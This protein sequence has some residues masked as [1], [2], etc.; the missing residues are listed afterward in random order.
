MPKEEEDLAVPIFNSIGDYYASGKK[1]EK[2]FGITHTELGA[3]FQTCDTG[4]DVICVSTWFRQ[5]KDVSTWLMFI[6]PSSV[7][8]LTKERL[9]LAIDKMLEK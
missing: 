3:I 4:P 2:P 6:Q 9:R 7:V 5:L 8:D 1:D